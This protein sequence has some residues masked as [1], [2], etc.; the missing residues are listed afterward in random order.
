MK[1]FKSTWLISKTIGFNKLK[2]MNPFNRTRLVI[3]FV[4]VLNCIFIL[5]LTENNLFASQPNNAP[6]SVQ[7]TALSPW[8]TT[9]NTNWLFITDT[10]EQGMTGGWYTEN[11]NDTGWKTLKS[12]L[13]WEKQNIFHRGWGWYRQKISIPAGY[14]GI[15][16][17]LKLGNTKSDDDVF[18]NGVRVGGIKSEYKYTN[19]ME[20]SYTVP[21]S[22]VHY[23]QTNTIAV[24]VWGG[25]LSFIGSNSGLAS[26]TFSAE[27][28]PYSLLAGDVDQAESTYQHIN[29]FDFS[30]RQKGKPFKL[31]FSFPK[32]TFDQGAAKLKYSIK[33]YYNA[34]IATSTVSISS[35][36]DGSCYAIVPVDSS[37][38]RSIYLKGRFVAIQTILNSSGATLSTITESID[39][40][41]FAKRDTLALPT[42]GVK[43]EE[44]SYGT[45]KLID[46]IDCSTAFSNEVHGYLQSSFNNKT[47]WY[48]TPGCGVTINV[49]EIL[50]KK[51]RELNNGW[52]AYKIGRG[53]LSPRKTYLLRI[54]YPEDK[55]RYCPIEI[56][57]GQNYMDAGWRSGVGIENDPYENWP[58]SNSWQYYDVIVPLDNETLGAG[59]TGSASAENGFWVYFMNKLNGTY[60]S[61]YQGGPAIASMKLYEIDPQT[62][63]PVVNKPSANLPQRTLMFDWERQADQE[64]AD[65]VNYAKLM[66]Y[67]A[68]S[69]IILK[70][71]TTN[72]SDPILG[73]TSCNIDRQNYWTRKEFIDPYTAKRGETPV[74]GKESVF[75]RYLA[76][77]KG[78]GI[79]FVPRVEYGGS[80]ALSWSAHATAI[81]GTP[82]VPNRFNAWCSD[83]LDP[84]TFTDM[85]NLV[86]HLFKPYVNENPQLTGMLWRIRCDMMPISYSDTDVAL[87]NSEMGTSVT[88][89]ILSSKSSEKNK[90]ADWWHIKRRDFHA[91]LVD[92]LKSYRSD[93]KLYYYNWDEDK[94][95]MI[96]KDRNSGDFYANLSGKSTYET[97]IT[98]RNNI[99]TSQYLDV[100]KSGN[101]LATAGVNSPDYGLRPS[102]Y[103]NVSGIELL[104]PANILH[105]ANN[106]DYL[107]YFK[108]AD[109]VS[110]SNCVSY[111]EIHARS[112]NPKYEGQS[113]TPG[114]PVYSMALELLDYF[115]ADARTL[116]FTAYTYGRGFANAHRRF[117]QAFLALPAI[118]G[119]VIDS[120]DVDVKVRA[121]KTSTETYIGVANKAYTPKTITVKI[122]ITSGQENMT[123]KNL[124]TGN[125]VSFTIADNQLQFEVNSGPVELNSY[126]LN[127]STG[128]KPTENSPSI[129]IFPNP[130]EENLNIKLDN[131]STGNINVT[132]FDMFGKV[133]LKD[134]YNNTNQINMNVAKLL[135]GTFICRVA[136][137]NQTV[138]LK[139]VK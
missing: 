18:V 39:Y 13:S 75:N 71:A 49:N 138:N 38:A 61:M 72:Y 86:E 101:F 118:K 109:G 45:L 69:P 89:S 11:L 105:L 30:D 56:Q 91:K 48:N 100:I 2:H 1:S 111:D 112:I 135:K 64:P 93:L 104:A 36:P 126:L 6:K 58:L 85:K 47:Q 73:Y 123:V 26:G 74:P 5:S 137:S 110:V 76:A 65:L 34:L 77:T 80:A 70:W 90:Y 57:I 120:S 3:R 66:G 7:V 37:T 59:G 117:A 95:S 119:N 31:K 22:L 40:L 21:A 94:F 29:L 115:H 133:I 102:L 50:G 46:E 52:F 16:L 33:D 63:S 139:F 10:L 14:E 107:N 54:E 130:V 78:S 136:T 127:A 125:N 106:S 129:V 124:V 114:G 131:S 60:F 23:G 25:N 19:M 113:M 4:L 42:L 27:L 108:T 62:N 41:S 9:L 99:T 92:L 32:S 134:V 83:L 28:N 121:Y 81:N 84:L 96:L 97:D 43:F 17:V 24:R 8:T 51:A 82:S 53:K 98:N 67:N 87:Y 44:T 88:R 122:P 79:N 116:T 132:I 20:R 68:I 15:P 55:P 12:G 35:A 103:S 128:L